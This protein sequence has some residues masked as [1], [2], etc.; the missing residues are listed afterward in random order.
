MPGEKILVIDD[1]ETVREVVGDILAEAGFKPL[2]AADGATALEMAQTRQP[3]LVLVDFIMP[4]MNGLKFCQ[5]FREIDNLRKVPLVLMS[6]KAESIG[7]KFMQV[8]DV[9]DAISKPFN[10][11]ALLAVIHHRLRGAPK[12]KPF[13][14][15]AAEP[16][17]PPLEFTPED[18]SKQAITEVREKISASMIAQAERLAGQ[19]GLMEA[20]TSLCREALSDT[21]I[22]GLSGSFR[23]VNPLAGIAAFA[24]S[25]SA[26]TVGDIIQ[27]ISQSNRTGMLEISE[28]DKRAAVYFKEG[29]VSFARLWGGSEEFLL[30]RYL[31]REEMVNRETLDRVTGQR[32]TRM[33]LG[34][35]LIKTGLLTRE[36]LTRVLEAQTTEIVYEIVRWDNASYTFH[37][38]IVSAE[39]EASGLQISASELLMEGYRRIDEWRLIGKA[40]KDFD[41]VLVRTGM[42]SEVNEGLSEEEALVLDFIDGSRTIHDIILATKKASFD[43][44]K[45]IYQLLS[46]KAVRKVR[47]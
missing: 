8:V 29:R 38:E 15:A 9:S 39:A 46:M 33:L 43:V 23:K 7:E 16:A 40:I 37:P 4:K 3:D 11:D 27:L 34:E 19:E 31:L 21:F 17:A 22:M 24:G 26:V 32:G 30:G 35:R 6:V 10:A 14:S 5:A 36:D 47:E 44:C 25:A 41:I 1:C 18:E 2:L 45:V 20:V 28:E 13:I 42:A 12:E